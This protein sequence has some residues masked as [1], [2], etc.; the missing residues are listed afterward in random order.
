MINKMEGVP[1]KPFSR[2]RFAVQVIDAPVEVTEIT[3]HT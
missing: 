1:L 2:L 3:D